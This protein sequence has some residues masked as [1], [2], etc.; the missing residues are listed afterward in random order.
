MLR[1]IYFL[2]VVFSL[3]LMVHSWGADPGWSIVHRIP[4]GGKGGWDY[5]AVEPGKSRLF[6]S[7]AQEVVVV[8][9]KSRAIVGSIAAAGV[10]GIA[11]APE[12]GRGFISN[13]GDGTV[14]VFRLDTLQVETHLPA[15]KN[16][17]AICYEP[18]TQRV[19]AFNG[20]SGTATAIDAK[21]EKVIGE[22]PLGGKPEFAQADGHGSVFDNLEDKDQVLK[23]NAATLAVEARWPLPAGSSPSGLAM[24]RERGR[25]FVGCGNQRLIVMDSGSGKIISS[26]PIGKGVDA[27]VYDPV[28]RRA[29]ASCGDGTMTVVQQSSTD[30]YTVT[31]TVPTAPKART[32]AYDGTTATAY[33]P[34]AKFGPM[35]APTADHPHSRPPVLPGSLE[36]VVM[37]EK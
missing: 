19:F 25:L 9:L 2:L 10:H 16:P 18:A 22:I 33:L 30:A 32:M 15:G 28:S 13:G 5:L 37:K 14:T 8:D 3:S 23:I 27:C 29:F 7:H 11:F 21:G 1:R 24:D 12:L 31:A 20:G 35:P 4:I 26:L 34:T 17:D 6:L 36:I